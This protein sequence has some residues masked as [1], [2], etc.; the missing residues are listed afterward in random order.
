LVNGRPYPGS[1]KDLRETGLYINSYGAKAEGQS[2]DIL[3]QIYFQDADIIVNQEIIFDDWGTLSEEERSAL[4]GERIEIT[5]ELFE[6]DKKATEATL[7]ITGVNSNGKLIAQCAFDKEDVGEYFGRAFTVKVKDNPQFEGYKL[8]SS[9]PAQSFMIEENGEQIKVL[10]FVNEYARIK[11]FDLKIKKDGCNETLDENQTF[12]F[13]VTGLNGFCMDVTVVGNGEVTIKNLPAGDYT[14]TELTEWSWRYTPTP[15]SQTIHSSDASAGI[16]QVS[17]TNG[18]DKKQWLSGDS[19]C[20]NWW[21][22]NGG[23]SVVRKDE[24]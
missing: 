21:G 2:E 22:G 23:T 6:G 15:T 12:I 24:E 1:L 7:I 19:Y 20:E 3:L 14:V 10:N 8:S 18:R 16:A 9:T 13:R 5:F 11:T 4:I 17:F